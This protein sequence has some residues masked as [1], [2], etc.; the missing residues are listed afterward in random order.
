MRCAGPV[1]TETDKDGNGGGVP[2]RQ[3][4]LTVGI[5]LD[6]RQDGR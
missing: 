1:F 6:H 4:R 3:L 5:H 2:H